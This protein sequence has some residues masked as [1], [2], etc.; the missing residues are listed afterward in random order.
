MEDLC[1]ELNGLLV[2]WF[3]VDCIFFT[4]AIAFR[5]L[6]VLDENSGSKQLCGA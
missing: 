6:K 4:R 2:L 1:A 5:C 3:F